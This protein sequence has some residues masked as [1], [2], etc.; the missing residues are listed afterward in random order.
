M[1]C[2][3]LDITSLSVVK[4]T[5]NANFLTISGNLFDMKDKHRCLFNKTAHTGTRKNTYKTN[6]RGTD[7]FAIVDMGNKFVESTTSHE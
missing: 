4:K 2:P 5:F 1:L 3:L 6:R 7:V